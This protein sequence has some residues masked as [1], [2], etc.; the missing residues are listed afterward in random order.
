[1]TSATNTVPTKNPTVIAQPA[2]TQTIELSLMGQKIILKTSADPERVEEVT[3]LVKS[4]LEA[5]SE[6]MKT[7]APHL[8]A[9]LALFD[10]AEEYIDAKKRTGEHLGATQAQAEKIRSWVTTELA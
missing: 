1:M 5:A 10:L 7:N 9:V 8:A 6:R 4:R 2:R 3:N